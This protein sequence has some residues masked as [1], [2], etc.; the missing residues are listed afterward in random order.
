MKNRMLGGKSDIAVS[1]LGL[2]CMGMSD[3]YGATN[4][5]ESRATLDRAL[6]RG[7]TSY[8]TADMYGMGKNEELL[9]PFLRA[10]R[11]RVIVATKFGIVRSAT[12]PLARGFEGGAA[13]VK[14]ACEASLK[15]LGVET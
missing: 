3:F 8:D 9:A 11:A 4:D 7:V 10:N 5:G 14:S 13:Y 1:A 12:D 2:G 15:R 6:D